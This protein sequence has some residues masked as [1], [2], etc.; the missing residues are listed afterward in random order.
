MVLGVLTGWL[1]RREREAIAYLVEENRCLRRQLGT[2]RLRLTDDDRRRLAAR[3]YRAGRAAMRDLAMIATP[4]TLLRRLV[5]GARA[6]SVLSPSD[7]R[8]SQ[9]LRRKHLRWRGCRLFLETETIGP[10]PWYAG[11]ISS[12]SPGVPILQTIRSMA[13]LANPN[14]DKPVVYLV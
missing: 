5:S 10:T 4:D 11:G 3:A 14:L 2:R 12:R 9:R 8:S 7:L 6:R 13:C 1:G